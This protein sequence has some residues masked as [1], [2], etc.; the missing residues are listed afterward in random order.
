MLLRLLAY[1]LDLPYFSGRF[2]LLT[3]GVLALTLPV[4]WVTYL[5]VERP[6]Q[7]WAH[8]R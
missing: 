2:W 6:A 8:R 3:A 4:A 5:L 7:R 1:W